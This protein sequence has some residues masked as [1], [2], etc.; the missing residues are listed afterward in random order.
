MLYIIGTPI[1]NIKDITLR[2]LDVLKSVDLILCED[3][4]ET[5]KLLNYYNIKKPLLS[6]YKEIEKKRVKKVIEL[7]KEGKEIALVCDRGTPGI[8][9]PAYLL[10]N[11]A[12]RNNIKVVPIP[13][14]SA[15]T[16]AMSI[17][18]FPL[19]KVYFLGFLPK[20]EIE[21]RKI[22]E[23]FKE[24]EEAVIF[25]ESVHRIDKTIN[26]LAEIMP[27]KEICICR[28][29][30]KMFEEILRGKIKDINEV[31]KKHKKKGEFVL[32]INGGENGF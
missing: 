20:K 9:D 29:L 1:G 8:S 7:L 26:L 32:I 2:G 21:K 23:R 11:E 6:Y 10:V 22:F 28:E 4:R 18:G 17:S 31:F 5:S 25:F 19:K 15:L 14:P 12:Y 30:T 13:G 24:G 27:E 3:T 16:A